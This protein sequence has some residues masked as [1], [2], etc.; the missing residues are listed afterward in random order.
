MKDVHI[1]KQEDMQIDNKTRAYRQTGRHT[2]RER[3]SGGHLHIY[4]Q[5]HNHVGRE[6]DTGIWTSIIDNWFLTSVQ[7]TGILTNMTDNCF[8][9]SCQ[10]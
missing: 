3:E 8:L 10:P 2:E 1:Y 6:R 4:K 5:E 7:D 9:T